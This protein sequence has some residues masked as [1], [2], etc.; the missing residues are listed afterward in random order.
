MLGK[1][2]E[3]WI[4][5]GIPLWRD[6]R[7]GYL[8]RKS[9]GYNNR[10]SPK[11]LSEM[12]KSSQYQA[13]HLFEMPDILD[14]SFKIGPNRKIQMRRSLH[15]F[16]NTIFVNSFIIPQQLCLCSWRFWKRKIYCGGI[17]TGPDLFFASTIFSHLDH[18]K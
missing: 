1:S 2:I 11:S 6:L 18:W 12:R 7:N 3:H 14:I 4:L 5:Q 15:E 8:S 10:G 17:R 16:L 13:S 9:K